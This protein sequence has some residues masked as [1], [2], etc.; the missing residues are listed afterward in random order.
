MDTSWSQ[1]EQEQ[2]HEVSPLVPRQPIPAY[3]PKRS[4]DDDP[5]SRHPPETQPIPK[6]TTSQPDPVPSAGKAKAKGGNMK[7]TLIS[8]SF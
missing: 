4:G 3:G 8:N 6:K 7:V 1:P 5:D 2:V